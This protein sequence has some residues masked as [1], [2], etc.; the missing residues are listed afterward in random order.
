MALTRHLIVL[1]VVPLAALLAGGSAA[2]QP[3]TGSIPAA[4]PATYTVFLKGQQIGREEATL[5]KTPEGW[6]ITSTSRLTVGTIQAETQLFEVRYG[7]D[8][9]PVELRVEAMVNGQRRALNTSFTLTTA[10]SEITQGDTTNQKTDTVSARTIVLPQNYYA[11]Y[12]ALAARL[13][14]AEKDQTLPAYIAPQIEVRLHIDDVIPE[15]I[16]TTAGNLSARRFRLTFQNPGLPLAV[17]M[18]VDERGRMARLEVPA[19]T[20]QVVREELATAMTRFEEVTHPGDEVAT[21]PASG[22]NL[23]ATVTRPVGQH[24]RL[25]FPTVILVAGAGPQDRNQTVFGIPIFGQIANALADAGFLVVRY[26]KRGVGQSGGRSEAATIQD[27]AEDVRSV[28]RYT[29]RRKDVDPRRVAVVGH[30]E[31]AAVALLAARKNKDI[32]ALVLIAG[33]GTTGEALVLEQQERLLARAKMSDDERKAKMELQHRIHDAVLRNKGWEDIP[34]EIRA[35]ADSPWFQ[36]ILAFDPARAMRD[37]RQPILIVQGTLDTQVPP[38][39]AEKLAALAR[40]RKNDG[41]VDV[42]VIEGVNHLLVPA[43]TGEFDEYADLEDKKVGPRVIEA[44]R[45]WLQETL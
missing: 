39:H 3:A 31:G 40:Q 34:P 13:A 38:H 22:F 41:G 42:Q 32:A 11:A 9:Q 26:D 33:P 5:S 45:E 17:D 16:Q 1:L 30:S 28:L 37:T 23:A 18:W 8:W 36:S 6:R 2:A 35:V 21:I 44:I 12:E 43:K 20:L 19:A 4:G 7:T 24:Q 25:R 14:T 10:I 27:Y 15:Q 29:R